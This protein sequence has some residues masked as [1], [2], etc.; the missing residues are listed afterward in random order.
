MWSLN[1]DGRLRD[2]G[3]LMGE[4]PGRTEVVE[5]GTGVNYIAAA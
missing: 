3:A 4:T 1:T 5:N 2:E